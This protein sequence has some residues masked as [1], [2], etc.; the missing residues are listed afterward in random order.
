MS[1]QTTDPR[2]GTW[3]LNVAKSTYSPG[4]PP[5]SGTLKIEASGQGEKVA[6]DGINAAGTP[7]MTRYTAHFDG[8][9][10]PLAGVSNADTVSLKRI[11]AWTSERTD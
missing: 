3:K 4:P 11:D 1:A 5:Q 6:A 10:Y 9:D 7:T 8:K 2:V